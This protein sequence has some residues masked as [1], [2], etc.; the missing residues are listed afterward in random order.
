MGKSF[1]PRRFHM[2]FAALRR[3]HKR[4]R[5]AMLVGVRHNSVG[6]GKQSIV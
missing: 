1:H 4:V 6:L 2:H 5:N 3:S